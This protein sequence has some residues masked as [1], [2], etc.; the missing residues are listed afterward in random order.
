MFKTYNISQ[1]LVYGITLAP[2]IKLQNLHLTFTLWISCLT[3]LNSHHFIY[4][5]EMI[6]I[7]SSENGAQ[8]KCSVNPCWLVLVPI[9]VEL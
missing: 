5:T 6:R 9:V 3:P 7:I 4:N 8:G 2:R 1:W